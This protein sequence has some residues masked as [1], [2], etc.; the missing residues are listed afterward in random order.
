M[1]T[2]NKSE[3][4]KVFI[5]RKIKRMASSVIHRIHPDAFTDI[6][7]SQY[8]SLIKEAEGLY[9]EYLFHDLALCDKNEL[10][11]LANLIGT[12]I[13]EAIYIKYY[14]VRSLDLQGDI[15]EFGVAQGSTSAFMAYLI[16]NTS[17]NIWLFDS[18][19][20]LPKPSDK[21]LLKNDI[22]KLG[23]ME[24]YEGTMACNINMVK[25]R[26]ADINFPAARTKIMPGFIEQTIKSTNLPAKVCFAYVDFDFYEPIATAL[27]YL[28]NALQKNGFIIVDDYDFFSTGVKTAVDEFMAEHSGKY[29]LYLPI[30]SAGH[31]CILEKI[32]E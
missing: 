15:C 24:A 12:Q 10:N 1:F 16:R 23:S 5:L 4:K 21:D 19:E 29:K 22:F 30:K 7:I 13:S 3:S 6:D 26:L 31:F 25:R 2:G 27:N 20:G 9:K 14:L 11:L 18:F 32:A 17:K 8:K 28:N